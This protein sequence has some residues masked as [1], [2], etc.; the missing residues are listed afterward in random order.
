M[1]KIQAGGEQLAPPSGAGGLK[2]AGGGLGGTSAP[3]LPEH[4]PLPAPAPPPRERAQLWRASGEQG[5]LLC[6]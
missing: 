3:R 5:R 2:Q 1:A 6:N 4:H